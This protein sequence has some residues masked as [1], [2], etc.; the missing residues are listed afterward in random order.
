MA[1][2][3]ADNTVFRPSPAE[4]LENGRAALVAAVSRSVAGVSRA[5]I[6]EIY[7]TGAE[8]D[9]V[10]LIKRV[11]YRSSYGGRG[12]PVAAF[13]RVKNKRITEWLDTPVSFAG[14]APPQPGR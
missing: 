11:D 8:W 13:F 12:V 4:P 3:M 9:T 10:I 1:Q 7:V 6:G 2:Y 5:E 14:A